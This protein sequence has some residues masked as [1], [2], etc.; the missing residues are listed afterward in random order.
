MGRKPAE[1]APLTP[2]LLAQT[3]AELEIQLDICRKWREEQKNSFDRHL[4]NAMCK[5]STSIR[6]LKGEQRQQEK[7]L[8]NMV[9]QGTAEETD[10]GIRI[11]LSEIDNDRRAA[12]LRYL[13]EL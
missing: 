5:L 2:D 11:F 12:F 9:E 6:E 10:A 8:K 4:I 13:R 1:R 7:H 3:L